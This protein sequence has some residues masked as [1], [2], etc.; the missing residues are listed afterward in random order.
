MAM[1]LNRTTNWWTT[2]HDLQYWPMLILLLP[3][4]SLRFAVST[5]WTNLVYHA[6]ARTCVKIDTEQRNWK[7]NSQA[8]VF[9][10]LTN[11]QAVMHYSRCSLASV[12]YVKTLTYAST[13]DQWAR[14]A[15]PLVSLHADFLVSFW[16]YINC[17]LLTYLLTCQKLTRFSFWRTDQWTSKASPLVIAWRVRERSHVSHGRR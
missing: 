5:S 6:A 16:R 3:A 15:Y 4:A 7:L 1:R 8:L 2:G 10:E 9:D 11:G 13:N 17:Y 14:T 12:A